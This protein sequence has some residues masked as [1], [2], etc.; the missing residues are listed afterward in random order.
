MVRGIGHAS[1]KEN[2]ILHMPCKTCG[3]SAGWLLVDSEIWEAH[4]DELDAC[5]SCGW[6]HYCLS[7]EPYDK[8]KI[9]QHGHGPE[10]ALRYEERVV[11]VRLAQCGR[12]QERQW[13]RANE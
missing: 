13:T 2:V 8:L 12:R 11:W 10:P 1:L 7:C 6:R 9:K 3:I 4:K 5:A